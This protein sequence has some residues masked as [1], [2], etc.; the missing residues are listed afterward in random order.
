LRL[1]AVY[2]SLVVD[3]SVAVARE[4]HHVDHVRRLL[5]ECDPGVAAPEQVRFLKAVPIDNDT[6][7]LWQSLQE[8]YRTDVP[9]DTIIADLPDDT[10]LDVAMSRPLLALEALQQAPRLVLLGEPGGGKSTVLRY[11]ALLLAQKA[12][13]QCVTVPGWDDERV[14]VP[15]LCPLGAVASTLAACGDAD[16]AL[17]QTLG[18]LLDGKQGIRAGLRD[19]LKPALRSGGVLLLF[20]GLDELPT[21]GS[22]PRQQIAHAVR[23][24]AAEAPVTPIVVT[25]RVLAYQAEGDWKLPD[26]EGWQ[27]RTI[28]P[29]AFG[30][31]R[32][33]V[34]QWYRELADQEPTL[35]LEQATQRAQTLIADLEANERLK[36]LVRSPLLL[37]MLSILHSNRNH[38]PQN[39]AQL[40]EEC[41]ELL[42][43]RWDTVRTPGMQRPGLLER[44]GNIPNLEIDQIRGMIH[45]LAV[46]AHSKPPGDDGRGL[47]DGVALEGEMLRFFRR[48]GCDDPAAKVE[49]VIQL[50]QETAGLLEARADD[51][52]AFPHLT[53]QEYLAACGLADDAE[54][55]ARAYSLW[56][57]TDADRWREVLLLLAGR[58]RIQGLRT[59]EREGLP[60]LKHLLNRRIGRK[61]KTATQRRR[62]AALAALTYIEYGES[63][64]LV[65]S[66]VDVVAEVEEPLRAA[67]VDLL[68]EHEPA[69]PQSDRIT[70]GFLLGEL[71]DP[72]FPVTIEEWQHSI[73]YERNEEFGS[74]NGYW[75][76]VRPGTYQIGGWEDGEES[77]DITLPG[78]WIARYPVTVAQYAMFIEDGGYQQQDYWTPEGWKWK[79]E[80]QIRRPRHWND[81]KYNHCNQPVIGLTW[82]EAVAFSSWL[83]EQ[84]TNILKMEG[85]VRLPTDAEWEIAAAYDATFC[86]GTFPWGEDNP[87]LS[88]AIHAESGLDSPVSVGTCLAGVAACGALDLAGNVYEWIASKFDTYP[89]GAA[90]LISDFTDEVMETVERG[91]SY[92]FGDVRCDK[93]EVN[94]AVGDGFHNND[95]FRIILAPRNA[96]ATQ[97]DD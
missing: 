17:W 95:G 89:H 29:L 62:D 14:P 53:F 51:Q 42:L 23:R 16:Q 19:H 30:Q 54:M 21:S 11:L 91:G 55:V 1:Q 70:A 26:E 46:Q 2:T 47:L 24:F 78:F 40:Y 9:L 90:E 67:L 18:E 86:R 6:H 64:A 66:Q 97:E 60:W 57:G 74:P 5:H 15:I 68:A 71:G 93:R 38:L 81:K 73:V 87:D 36:P 85:R 82:Y 92:W 72:R 52:Y 58:L 88:H 12:L 39:R 4:Q 84:L 37:T 96:T 31:V 83:D 79:V 75:S 27:V 44:L 41:V 63:K 3:G 50:L 65:N 48:L 20:D 22:N 61:E 35:S 34:H 32:Q 80:H 7:F 43:D 8:S 25:S 45:K 49:I 69:V 94:R 76:Y 77:A 59:V 10:L 28:Q 33:F 13:G 56:T